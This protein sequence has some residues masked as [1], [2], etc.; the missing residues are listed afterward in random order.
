MHAPRWRA[1]LLV[2]PLFVL[3]VVP[4]ALGAKEVPPVDHFKCYFTNPSQEVARPLVLNDQ[5][6]EQLGRPEQ[7]GLL[8]SQWFCNPVA[9]KTHGSSSPINHP[10]QHLV[11]YFIEPQPTEA[12]TV[13]VTNQF[14]RGAPQT[15]MVGP[16]AYLAVPTQKLGFRLGI[17]DDLDHFKCYTVREGLAPNEPRV[18]D[19][20]FPGI[21]RVIVSNPF[22]FCNPVNKLD[23]ATGL[24]FPILNPDV[25]L[26]CYLI[27]PQGKGQ[28][29][30]WLNQLGQFTTNAD[31]SVHICAPSEKL[32]FHPSE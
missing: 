9:K 8:K 5:F 17:P 1:A 19:D 22:L 23:L 28:P 25:H 32:A 12:W 3:S 30:S 27:T 24:N 21:E 4:T 16:P 2:L 7:V 20:Q 13:T 11:F 15:L 29:V 31:P 26:V 18:L 6:D 14:L 10:D